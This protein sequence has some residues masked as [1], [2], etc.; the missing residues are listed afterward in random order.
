MLR[1]QD[2]LNGLTHEGAYMKG[3]MDAASGDPR[4]SRYAEEAHRTLSG[5]LDRAEA[6]A[7]WNDVE[8]FDVEE[9]R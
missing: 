3:Y 6:I 9:E 4:L 1:T 5:F 2:S 8:V 7:P